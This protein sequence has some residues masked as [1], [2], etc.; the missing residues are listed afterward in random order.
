MLTSGCIDGAFD[1]AEP[2]AEALALLTELAK[3]PEWRMETD[4]GTIRMILYTGW[5]PGTTGHI[6]Q[7][8]D[9]SFYDGTTMHR[10]V[11]DF[12]IQGGDPTGTG[13]G[14]S[15]PL[16]LSDSI[17]LEIHDGLDF[18]SG[19]VGLARWTDDT[20]DSQYFITEKPAIHLSQP[21]GPTGMVFGAY[22]LFAQVFQG[23]DV[24]RAIAQVE[25]DAN[26]KPTT[27]VVVHNTTILDPPADADL[28]NL[29][30][31]VH[32]GVSTQGYVGDLE[33]PRIVVADHPATFRFS[34]DT[35]DSTDS[36]DQAP[37]RVESFGLTGPEGTTSYRTW[38]GATG[39]PCTF[40]DTIRFTAPGDY[41]IDLGVDEVAFQVIPWHAEYASFTGTA[42]ASA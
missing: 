8:A 9:R 6:I 30:P 14:G 22:S 3:F 20:G 2:D 13:E 18:G 39:D 36:A 34:T 19:A 42:K 25:T 4:H 7:L 28:I 31:D 37:C 11:D 15:G 21:T 41:V 32:A 12:V 27:D 35:T 1:A 23:Q 10:V 24:V 16:G 38:N 40:E 29:I 26:D 33:V 17:P 5:T